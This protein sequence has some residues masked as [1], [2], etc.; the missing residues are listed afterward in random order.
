MADFS[1]HKMTFEPFG[2][3]NGVHYI[4]NNKYASILHRDD[5]G[6][7]SIVNNIRGVFIKNISFSNYFSDNSFNLIRLEDDGTIT[8]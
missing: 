6:K 1:K 3:G 2:L 7:F 4:V 5:N 8:K